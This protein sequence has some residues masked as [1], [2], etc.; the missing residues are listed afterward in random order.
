MSYT[1]HK[2]SSTEDFDRCIHVRQVVF[3]VEQECPPDTEPDA[4]DPVCTQFLATYS[5][6]N[7]DSAPA[8]PVGTARLVPVEAESPTATKTA[9]LGRLAVLKEHRGKGLGQLLVKAVEEEAKRLGVQRIDMHA[10]SYK[11]RWYEKLGYARLEGLDEFDEDGIP[12][13]HMEKWIV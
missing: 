12:H 4:K 2:V 1:V 6:N 8:S 13:V 11:Q 9:M 3:V 5:D 7:T 10:Q